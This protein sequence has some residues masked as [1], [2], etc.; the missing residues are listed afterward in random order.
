MGRAALYVRISQDRGGDAD[1]LERQEA[2]CR[3]AA[4]ARGHEVVEVVQDRSLSAYDRSVERPGWLRVLS[5]V[6]AGQVDVVIAH[7]L[8]RIARRLDS[9]AE[10]VRLSE[11]TGVTIQTADG[12]FDLG[13]A[14]GR[15]MATIIVSVAAFESERKAERHR[16]ANRQ[17]R[18]Q[19]TPYAAGSRTFGYTRDGEIVED[20]AAAIREAVR[21]LLAGTT[22][23]ADL[24]RQW[25]D[26][27][28]REGGWSPQG[29]RR[30]LSSAR[31]A[32]RVTYLDEEV[33]DS[34]WPAIID[35]ADH[36]AMKGLV[37]TRKTGGRR[38]TSLLGGIARCS[39]CGS[40]AKAARKSD[41]TL[42]Y[43]CPSS[44]IYTPREAADAWASTLVAVQLAR[45]AM[46]S[47]DQIV[48]EQDE[49]PGEE[50]TAL[51][52]RLDG[53]AD[54]YADGLIDLRQLERGSAALRARIE[55]ARSSAA[56]STTK[57]LGPG[58]ITDL[59]LN[60]RSVEGRRAVL[61]QF[62]IT[63]KPRGRERGVPISEQVFVEWREPA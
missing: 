14:S 61:E 59:W 4:Q 40:K 18:A 20:E 62:D 10:L 49:G 45:V 24:A 1:P 41:G 58:A 26:A 38:P 63:L 29:V 46:L 54:S 21:A 6:E 47:E 50:V 28:L 25:N 34:T 2:A 17:R 33:G 35:Y 3:A 11:S 37:E 43:R 60:A 53:L 48:V 8:D 30:A 42:V 15:M 55:A 19:G 57:P 23:Y 56:A 9:I 51:Q 27:G 5:M 31:L 44:H 7:K 22:S 16:D 39:V 52:Q 12:E 36:L 13:T 32:G